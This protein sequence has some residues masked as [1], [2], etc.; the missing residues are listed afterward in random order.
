MTPWER[1]RRL[2]HPAPEWLRV[3]VVLVAF[4]GAAVV[5]ALTDTGTTA[6]VGFVVVAAGLLFLLGR[7]GRKGASGS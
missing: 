5:A 6:A 4:V 1:W 2:G 3:L 7:L